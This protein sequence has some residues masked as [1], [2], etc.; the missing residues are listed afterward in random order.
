MYSFQIHTEPVFEGHTRTK[1]H[2][3]KMSEDKPRDIPVHNW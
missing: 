2:P 1:S 3:I